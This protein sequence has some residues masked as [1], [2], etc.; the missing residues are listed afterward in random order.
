MSMPFVYKKKYGQNFLQDKTIIDHI[1]NAIDPT[2]Q[3]L[4]IEIGPGSGALTKNLKKYGATLVAYEIDPDTHKYLDSLEDLKTHIIYDDFL[5]RDLALD[6]QN[7]E[8]ND[9][10][11]IGNLPYYI[12]TPIILHLIESHITA[13]KIVIM[14]QDEVADR[15][16]ATPG[17]REYGAITVLLNY[18]FKVDKLFVV[19][20]TK[21]Y[22]IPNVDS[23]VICLQSKDNCEDVNLDKFNQIIKASFQFKRKNMRNNLKQ[24]DLNIVEEVLKHHGFTLDNRAEDL[25]YDIFVELTRSLFKS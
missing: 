6:M 25:S 4:I 7:Y 1:V 14:V 20:K 3:D 15:F 21:F 8:Y 16:S 24:Y 2:P 11:I 18:Y 23:A 10:Y 13:K 22:P 5:K 12:T 9:L 19:S 17:S